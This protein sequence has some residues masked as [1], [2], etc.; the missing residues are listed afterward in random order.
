MAAD[1]E[2]T[3]RLSKSAASVGKA[4]SVE[5]LDAVRWYQGLERT[6]ELVNDVLR[7]RPGRPFR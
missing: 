3:Q 2:L 1:A 5:D 7:G 6:Y 4:A